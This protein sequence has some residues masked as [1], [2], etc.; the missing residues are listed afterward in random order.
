MTDIQVQPFL[1]T[2]SLQ[3]IAP[4]L[5]AAVAGSFLK[6][7]MIIPSTSAPHGVAA[8]PSAGGGG[9]VPMSFFQNLSTAAPAGVS[10]SSTAT[11]SMAAV[12]LS[13]PSVSVSTH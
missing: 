10:A 8:A 4:S 12:A 9:L 5:G 2:D 3:K 1:L 7:F 6:A 11:A 13:T